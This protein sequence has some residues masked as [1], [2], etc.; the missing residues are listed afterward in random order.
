VAARRSTTL[1][2][3]LMAAIPG[4]LVVAGG[5][6]AVQAYR[7]HELMRTGVAGLDGL[8]WPV[9]WALARV[10]GLR[11]VGTSGPAIA[12]RYVSMLKQE[13]AYELGDRELG[14]DY[15]PLGDRTFVSRDGR[16][17]GPAVGPGQV[18]L[19]N[20]HRLGWKGDG[21]ELAHRSNAGPALFYAAS[22][23]GETYRAADGALDLATLRYNGSGERAEAYLASVRGHEAAL[24][25]AAA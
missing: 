22:V 23:F 6:G 18:L 12:R 15:Y 8:R 7:L 14:A 2:V 4:S 17:Y 19:S 21:R 16:M 24:F 9:L 20:A 25:G 11:L 1:G 13:A 5:V 3:V 10:F